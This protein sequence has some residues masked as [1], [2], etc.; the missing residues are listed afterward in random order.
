[1][2]LFL[3]GIPLALASAVSI[4]KDVKYTVKD[5]RI[6]Q[7][8]ISLEEQIS[9]IDKHFI[10]ILDYSGATGDIYRNGYQ[11]M[12]IKNTQYGQY[13]GLRRYLAEKGYYEEAIKYAVDKYNNIANKEKQQNQY[14]RQQRIHK[15]EQMIQNE[16]S[17]YWCIDKTVYTYKSKYKAEQ[18]A[19][20][21]LNYLH[22]NG[23][24]LSQC[25][26]IMGG[27]SSNHNHI[28]T[29]HIKAPKSQPKLIR[30]Y[31]DDIKMEIIGDE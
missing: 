29:W 25:N 21:V 1:M 31:L 6:P 17:E 20:K 16:P 14:E 2:S 7:A 13:G 24:E 3:L 30:Q 4:K 28:E 5:L 10:D 23:S 8:S 27:H 9:D 26:I 12:R 19:N 11:D 22:N 15:Y 18:E